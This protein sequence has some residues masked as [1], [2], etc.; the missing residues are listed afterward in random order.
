MTR[1]NNA[2]TEPQHRVL[3]SGLNIYVIPRDSPQLAVQLYTP[4]GSDILTYEDNESG[5][6]LS[7]QPGSAHYFEHVLFIMPPLGKNGRP[8]IYKTKTPKTK[9]DLRDGLT[10]LKRLG[11]TSPNAYTWN[12]VTN[13]HFETT[14]NK[15]ECLDTLLGFVF[16]PYLPQ[17]RF[18][19]ETGTILNEAQRSLNDASELVDIEWHKQAF[20]VHGAR[21]PVIGTLE[22]IPKISIEDVLQMHDIFYRPSNMTLMIVGSANIDEI[23]GIAD[24]RLRSLGRNKYRSPPRHVDQQEPEHIAVKNNFMHPIERDDIVRPELM[25]GWKY[26]LNPDKMNREQI[27]DTH[28]GAMFIG[29]MLCGSGSYG[30]EELIAQGADD[31][32]TGSSSLGFFDHGEILVFSESDMPHSIEGMIRSYASKKSSEGFSSEEIEAAR[33]KLLLHQNDI[34][35]EV[36]GTY[37]F[38]LSRWGAVTGSPLSYFEAMKRIETITRDEINSWAG[39]MLQDQKY[40]SVLCIPKK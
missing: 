4:F 16:A 30:R 35:Q 31:R 17:D 27:I 20:H 26:V 5:K 1:T 33:S 39:A 9:K 2:S 29:Q 18:R 19:A 32:T 13:Y 22:S 10:E 23:S 36:L 24:A 34:T 25:M 37:V 7:V 14:E 28:L 38:A 12:D 40:T 3:E 11:A 21:L 15:M 8:I 6:R